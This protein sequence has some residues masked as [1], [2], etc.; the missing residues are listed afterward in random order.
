MFELCGILF[1]AWLFHDLRI[2]NPKKT[3]GVRYLCRVLSVGYALSTK[4][5]SH[6][7]R[8]KMN[9]SLMNEEYQ[10]LYSVELWL[11]IC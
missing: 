10:P 8:F 2:F 9:V 1:S 7:Q 6:S 3:V 11:T 4:K 5:H